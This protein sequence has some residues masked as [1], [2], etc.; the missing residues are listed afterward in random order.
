MQTTFLVKCIHF[1]GHAHFLIY[2]VHVWHTLGA[3]WFC[4][5]KA[6]ELKKVTRKN[7]RGSKKKTNIGAKMI[8]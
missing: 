5:I 3:P 7:H 2:I 4:I 8:D 1:C 6:L